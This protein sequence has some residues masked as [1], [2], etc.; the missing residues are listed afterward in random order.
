MKK[1]L[2]L[3]AALSLALLVFAPAAQA[4]DEG[5]KEG[6]KTMQ[7]CLGAGEADDGYTLTKKKG[8]E[9][10]VIQVKGDDSFAAHVGHE[11]KLTGTWEKNED[12]KT[13]H[14]TA[15]EHVAATCSP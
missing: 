5:K 8:D 14:A 1:I 12:G 10:K 9:T 13:F 4:G 15:M 11:V 2:S 7:G 6:V 3:T